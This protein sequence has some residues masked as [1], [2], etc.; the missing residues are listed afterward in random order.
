MNPLVKEQTLDAASESIATLLKEMWPDICDGVSESYE[1]FCEESEKENAKFVY[2][3]GIAL[4][5][6]PQNGNMAVQSEVTWGVKHKRKSPLS[7]V[8]T[9]QLKLD[10]ELEAAEPQKGPAQRAAEAVEAENGKLDAAAVDGAD[11]EEGNMCEGCP[12]YKLDSIDKR[13]KCMALDI[14]PDAPCNR[15]APPQ[16]PSAD[17]TPAESA[18][19]ADND[20]GGSGKKLL[21]LL[22]LKALKVFVENGR[23][24]TSSLQ[25]QLKVGYIKASEIMD[26]LEMAGKIGP[27]TG[28]SPRE[29]LI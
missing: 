7:V 8:D 4:S 28:N 27:A 10:M 2:K 17:E 20:V 25:R 22:A 23:V 18:T 3:V 15:V 24:S 1:I 14:P 21:S 11:E 9:D 12:E 13:R 6:A 5:I 19:T 16:V 26:E 29:L